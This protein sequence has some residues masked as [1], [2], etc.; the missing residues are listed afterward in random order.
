[1]VVEFTWSNALNLILLSLA[2]QNK[3]TRASP[4]GR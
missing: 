3:F 2:Y 1:M 4:I